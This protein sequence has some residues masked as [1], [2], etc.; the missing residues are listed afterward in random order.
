[1]P[2]AFY[3]TAHEDDWEL[4]RGEYAYND[5]NDS[6]NKVVFIH[7]TAGDAGQTDG[8]WEAREQGAVAAVRSTLTQDEMP[9]TDINDINGH[10]IQ[11]YVCAN[12][13]IYFMRLPDG[14]SGTGYPSTNF[15][16]LSQL[17]DSG[18]SI[19]AVDGSATY[20]SWNDFCDTLL[21]IIQVERAD[22]SDEHP[23]I[24]AG[25]YSATT[26][27]G[28]HPD[29]KAT[30]DAVRS[31]ADLNQFNRAW[32]LTYCIRGC[33]ENLRGDGLEHKKTTFDEY[34]NEVLR[35]TTS[36]GNPVDPMVG[37]W[38]DWG[39]RSYARL[40]PFDEP[41]VDDP[42]APEGCPSTTFVS[43]GFIDAA[44]HPTHAQPPRRREAKPEA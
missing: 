33:S 16:S 8:W 35:V 20:V 21:A 32:F 12:T 29:H 1:M 19:T 41:D 43:A 6:A 30:A 27:P 25:D 28:D 3:V 13:V 9:I 5:A 17:R 11:R 36:N 24:N 22:I 4:F 2:I 34:G 26:N 23:W 31:F 7:T 39:A 10:T 42:Q 37:E 15:E 44:H 14:G 40:V 38:I 18:K